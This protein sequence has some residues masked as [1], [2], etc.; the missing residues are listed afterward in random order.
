MQVT[1]QFYKNHSDSNVLNK[2]LENGVVLSATLKSDTSVEEPT[3]LLSKAF[4][5]DYNYL[6]CPEFNKYYYVDKPTL[7]QGSMKNIKCREDALMSLADAILGLKCTV[8]RNENFKNGYLIDNQYKA[9]AYEQVVTKPFPH[10][11]IDNS[12]I[13]MTMG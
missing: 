6:Y 13:L 3:F 5:Y 12:V 11:M 4:N 9:V 7:T 2:S 1:L 8:A 10:A